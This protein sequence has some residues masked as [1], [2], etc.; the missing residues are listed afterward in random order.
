MNRNIKTAVELS[1]FI[2]STN[3]PWALFQGEFENYLIF[4][5]T[6][7]FFESINNFLF[8]QFRGTHIGFS[9][10][11]NLYLDDILEKFPE[12]IELNKQ[13]IISGDSLGGALAQIVAIK[14]KRKNPKRVRQIINI[15]TGSPRPGGPKFV[16][17]SLG[18]AHFRYVHNMD[19]ITKIPPG[20]LGYMHNCLPII[21]K[22]NVGTNWNMFDDHNIDYY[23]ESICKL[24]NWC[25]NHTNEFL[26]NGELRNL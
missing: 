1:K 18:I 14:I 12:L 11:S 7:N 26:I 4:K 20:F 24:Y 17:N 21:L 2:Y 23:Y 3:S 10:L 13:L 8:L 16:L 22:D 9:N 5:G 6:S 15:T 25:P 19:P